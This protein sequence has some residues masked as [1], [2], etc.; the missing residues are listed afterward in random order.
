[1]LINPDRKRFSFGWLVGWLYFTS[2]R[3]R[4]HFRDGTPFSCGHGYRYLI[5]D[6]IVGELVG[7]ELLFVT[8]RGDFRESGLR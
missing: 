7:V 5:F 6:P 8:P 4:G 3:E 2:H 1:M